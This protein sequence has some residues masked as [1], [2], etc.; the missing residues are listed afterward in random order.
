MEEIAASIS[1]I[2]ESMRSVKTS[3]TSLTSSIEAAD[4]HWR[5]K[6]DEAISHHGKALVDLSTT[7]DRLPAG[8]ISHDELAQ[9]TKQLGGGFEL[10]EAELSHL[11]KQV[12]P[13][14][15]ANSSSTTLGKVLSDQALAYTTASTRLNHR[16]HILNKQVEEEA[17]YRI[18]GHGRNILK[19]AWHFLVGRPRP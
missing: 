2:T 5:D 6:I 19:R 14:A 15:G 3:V 12:D 7:I 13:M 11:R 18:E 8:K 1:G 17:D 9:L 16:I 4:D 10:V